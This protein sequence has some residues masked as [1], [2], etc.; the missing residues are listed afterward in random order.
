MQKKND[1][2]VSFC[3]D[4]TLE[5]CISIGNGGAQSEF[6]LMALSLLDQWYKISICNNVLFKI[7]GQCVVFNIMQHQK[8][9][10]PNNSSRK[11]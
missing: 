1:I 6:C 7:C 8:M 3:L 11:T 9:L 5:P 10:E 4:D 2:P